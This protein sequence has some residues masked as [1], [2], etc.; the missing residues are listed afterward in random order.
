MAEYQSEYAA[1]N[2]TVDIYDAA[3][4]QSW[5]LAYMTFFAISSSVEVFDCTNIEELINFLV[6]IHTNDAYVSLPLQP[7]LQRRS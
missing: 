1:S 7:R 2:F 3:G 6:W 5:P 4:N